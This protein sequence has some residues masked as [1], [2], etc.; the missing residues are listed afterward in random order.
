M[1]RRADQPSATALLARLC[2]VQGRAGGVAHAQPHARH[3]QELVLVRLRLDAARAGKVQNQVGN[4]VGLGFDANST[5]FQPT[6]THPAAPHPTHP[7]VPSVTIGPAPLLSAAL[8]KTPPPPCMRAHRPLVLCAGQRPAPPFECPR[9]LCVL[10]SPHGP[11][12]RDRR[13]LPRARLSRGSRV[14]GCLCTRW[15][16]TPESCTAPCRHFT[17]SND[18]TSLPPP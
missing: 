9:R 1:A 6:N 8:C 7:H 17:S 15:G 13:H 2:A 16:G 18:S 11:Q 12:P 3:A 4:W 10:H 5:S 14:G